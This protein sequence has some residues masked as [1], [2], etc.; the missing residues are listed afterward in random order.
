MAFTEQ[1]N[2]EK[3]ILFLESSS[4]YKYW[5]KA[6]QER[7]KDAVKNVPPEKLPKMMEEFIGRENR[8]KMSE[9][10]DLKEEEKRQ[11]TNEIRALVKEKEEKEQEKAI[12]SAEDLLNSLGKTT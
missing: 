6:T 5:G 9:E 3:F 2:A 7:V 11:K 8:I 1:I 10:K 12:L 4:T